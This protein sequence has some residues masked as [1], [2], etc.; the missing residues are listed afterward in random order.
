MVP[1]DAEIIR[2]VKANDVRG[3]LSLLQQGLA[4]LTDCD[5]KGRPLLY[6]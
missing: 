3:M 2:C 6:V 5:P 4:S 1:E